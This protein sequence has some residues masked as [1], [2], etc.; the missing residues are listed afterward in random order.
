MTEATPPA[1]KS[2]AVAQV[3]LTRP[4]RVGRE[5]EYIARVLASPMWHGDGEFTRRAD[6][7]LRELTGAPAVL[8]TPSCTHALE[9]AAILL[10]LGPGDEVICP[11]F[12][13]TST[14]TA[15]AIRGATPVF[16]DVRP[17]TLNLDVSLVEAAI[18]ERTRAVFV[19]HYGGIAADIDRLVALTEARGLH[20]VEDNAH[21]LGG[22]WNGRHLGTFGGLA[23]QSFHD[24]KNLTSGEGGALLIND[25]SLRGRAEVV[26]EKGTDRSSFLRGEVDKY[27]WQDVGSSFLMSEVSA[28]LLVAQSEGFEVMQA[29]RHEV[30]DRYAEQL[31]PW[32]ADVGATTM[33]VPE[34][35]D[36]PA[37]VYYVLM[38][39]AD[40]QPGLMA[41]T[42]ARE[43]TTVFHYQPLDSSPAGRRLGRTPHPCTVTRD[44]ASRI[45]RLP[46]HPGLSE[47]DVE[48]VVDAVTSYRPA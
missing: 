13:F 47:D 3:R 38:P 23:T 34:G 40:D 14:A 21:G 36:H 5:E 7:W 25:E 35:N 43:V 37:H 1:T 17:D 24:T 20:L 32:A 41:H 2:P 8:T 4:H 9:L 6:A 16:V 42:G 44:V 45:V 30:W 46:L 39:S 48:R 19:V 28:A 27:T 15:I 33:V 31:A 18:T 11:S 29:R 12:T 22:Y 26:R 10:D